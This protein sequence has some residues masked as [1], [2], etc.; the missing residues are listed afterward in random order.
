MAEYI[1]RIKELKRACHV[2][3]INWSSITGTSVPASVKHATA[4]NPFKQAA[5]TLSGEGMKILTFIQSCGLTTNREKESR[6]LS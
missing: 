2:R 3:G 1:Y 4:I 6:W 5:L